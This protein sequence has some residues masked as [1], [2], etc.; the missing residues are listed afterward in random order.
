MTTSK[1]R[2]AEVLSDIVE[3]ILN[4]KNRNTFN[5]EKLT[6]KVLREAARRLPGSSHQGVEKKLRKLLAKRYTIDGSTILN[7]TTIEEQEGDE[8]YTES[9][10]KSDHP[11]ASDDVSPLR[12]KWHGVESRTVVVNLDMDDDTVIMD[13]SETQTW[14]STFQK[15]DVRSGPYSQAERDILVEAVKAYARTHGLESEDHS[16]LFAERGK[17]TQ[18]EHRGAFKV[19]ASALPDRT[20][21]SVWSFLFRIFHPGNYRG[22]WTQEEDQ[23]LMRMSAE[24]PGDWKSMGAAL[25]RMPQACKDRFKEIKLGNAKHSG[26]WQQ[27]EVEKL[28]ASVKEILDHRGSTNNASRRLIL[29]DIDWGIV[30]TQVGSRTPI[31]CLRKWYD[32]VSPSMVSRGEWGAGDDKR[33]LKYLYLSGALKEYE[34]DWS[35]AVQGRSAS[36]SKRRWNLMRKSL[37]NK[38]SE[39]RQQVEFLVD[40]YLPKLISTTLH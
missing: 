14:R 10:R 30:S 38:K 26:M 19:I 2:K 22:K 17:R 13:A 29:D 35:N 5:A 32:E 12:E 3:G 23:K 4:K 37:P 36:Q 7:P 9:N 6:K 16:W 11:K 33:L 20:T 8:E 24:A 27:H 28:E 1:K 31:Q 18:A 25:G 21:K 34:V 15:K 39:F 40:K